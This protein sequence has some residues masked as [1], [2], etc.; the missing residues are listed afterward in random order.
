MCRSK[1]MTAPSGSTM[2]TADGATFAV[3]FAT[4]QFLCRG[5]EIVHRK[6]H[7][8]LG[9]TLVTLEFDLGA[10]AEFVV[11]EDVLRREFANRFHRA[12]EVL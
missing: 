9:L 8:R 3:E 7:A 1:M 2:D 12:G 10:D 4:L 11:V 5:R 6:Y